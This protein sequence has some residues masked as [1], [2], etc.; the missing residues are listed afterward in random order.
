MPVIFRTVF[1]LYGHSHRFVHLVH[2]RTS[3]P[4]RAAARPAC[5]AKA[6]MSVCSD[7]ELTIGGHVV[8]SQG[9]AAVS[10]DRSGDRR[11]DRAAPAQPG[12]PQ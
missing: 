8:Q 7:K 3:D 1:Y 10:G 5:R 9:E 4:A 12:G 6:R 2:H 11:A